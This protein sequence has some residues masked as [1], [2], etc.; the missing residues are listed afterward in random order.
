MTA[1]TTQS[2]AV[3]APAPAPSVCA[4]RAKAL[5]SATTVAVVGGLV[6][7]IGKP[8]QD[9]IQAGAPGLVALLPGPW[10]ACGRSL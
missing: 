7:R 9:P 4:G 1:T 2:F 3:P 6:L 10:L 5:V 8:D